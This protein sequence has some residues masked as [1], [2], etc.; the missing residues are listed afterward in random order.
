[1]ASI[2]SRRWTR[3]RRRC[4]CS[5]TWSSSAACPRPPSA[6]AWPS[7]RRRPS[8]RSWSA[9][10]ACSCSTAAPTGS[11]PTAAGLRLAPACA[12]RRRR[13]RRARRPGRDACVDEQRRLVVATTRHVADHFLPGVDRRRRPRRRPHRPRRGRHAR[14]SPRPCARARPTSASRRARR[15]RSGC[16]RRWS[17]PRRSSPSSAAGTRGTAAA[18]RS[19]ASDLVGGRRSRC[20]RPGS[21]TLDVVEAALAP[22]EFGAGRRPDRGRQLGRGARRGAER[23]RP[24]RSCPAAGSPAD[25]ATGALAVVAGARPLIEQPVRVVWRGARPPAGSARR[26]VDGAASRARPTAQGMVTSRPAA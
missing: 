10:S 23:R 9:S 8:C 17:P 20:R 19:P 1:M 12:E 16:G 26:L 13:R 6:T 15:R 22:F 7:R 21:G 11:A 25:L 3:R 2:P 5:S 14:A 24:W 4:A 18:G